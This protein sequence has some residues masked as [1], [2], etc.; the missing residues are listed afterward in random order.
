MERKIINE[1]LLLKKQKPLLPLLVRGARQVG[2]SYII[3]QFG[4]DPFDNTIVLNFEYHPEYSQF[5]E[6][7]V[8]EEILEKIYLTLGEA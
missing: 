6:S 7:L 8:P 3:E 5:F 4:N 2:K 1:L